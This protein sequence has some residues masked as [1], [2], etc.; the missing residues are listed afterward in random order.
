MNRLLLLIGIRLLTPAYDGK[1][2]HCRESRKP[3]KFRT[4]RFGLLRG[5]T[6]PLAGA[7]LPALV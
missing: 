2:K 1:R 7:E 5:I 6:L 3:Q 4:H